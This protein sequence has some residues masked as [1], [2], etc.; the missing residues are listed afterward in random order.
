MLDVELCWWSGVVWGMFGLESTTPQS[1]LHV[2][3]NHAV[4]GWVNPPDNER[5]GL[6]DGLEICALVVEK[7]VVLLAAE[8]RYLRGTIKQ[9]TTIFVTSTGPTQH[10]V[11]FTLLK[12]LGSRSFGYSLKRGAPRRRG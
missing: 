11:N 5:R 9:N 12:S 7:V 4:R 8:V 10:R 1:W 6:L 3:I 2:M